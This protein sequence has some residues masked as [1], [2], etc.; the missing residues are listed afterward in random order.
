V[1]VGE[2]EAAPWRAQYGEPRGAVGGMQQGA[3]EGE[4][5]LDFGALSSGSMSTAR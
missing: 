3:G 2:R 4:E 5:V 1:E